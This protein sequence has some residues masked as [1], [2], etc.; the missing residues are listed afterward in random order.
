MS[1]Y[2]GGLLN[3]SGIFPT[4]LFPGHGTPEASEASAAGV[5]GSGGT[6][7]NPELYEMAA[8]PPSATTSSPP[9]NQVVVVVHA[10][11][12]TL[13]AARVPRRSSGR[14]ARARATSGSR[15]GPSYWLSLLP[16]PPH[17]DSAQC[18]PGRT[19]RDLRQVQSADH[20]GLQ[21]G[22]RGVP[23]LRQRRPH[24]ARY[25]ISQIDPE[26]NTST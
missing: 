5:E 25:F 10:N 15:A 17:G 8:A 21:E 1:S 9:I 20:D 14:A 19:G 13:E 11:E 16:G 23:R 24:P 7:P 12:F 26:F 4:L 3:V 18:P 22:G 2:L 6:P